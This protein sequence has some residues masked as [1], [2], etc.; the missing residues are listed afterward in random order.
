VSYQVLARKYRPQTFAEVVG[1]EHVVR[2]LSNAIATG[3]IAHAFLFVGPRGIGKTSIA[4]IL[5]KALNC[6]NGPKADFDPADP[7]CL[8]IAEGRSLDVIE[9]DGA[10]NNGVEQ[11]RDLRDNVQYMPSSGQFKVYIIDEVHMLSLAAFNA[12]LKTLEEPPAHVKFV[13]ATTEVH[14]VPAT[15]LS[16]CQRFD[17]RRIGDVEIASHLGLIAEKE[18]ITISA[19]AL[20]LLARNAE[21]GLRDAESALDQLITFC[22]KS[23]EEKDVLEMFGLTGIREIWDLAEA[24]QAADAEPAIRQVRQLVGR[25]K[26]LLQLTR[27]LVRY[28]RN[29]LIYGISPELAASQLDASE[30]QHFSAMQP[31][32]KRELILAWIEELVRL[33]EKMRHALVKEVMFEITIIR[34]SQQREKVELEELLLQITGGETPPAL[35]LPPRAEPVKVA[36]TP[37]PRPEPAA[38][39]TPAPIP[40][41]DPTPTPPPEP[42]PKPVPEPDPVPP[43]KPV[44]E[45]KPTAEVAPGGKA[46]RAPEK[47]TASAAP[48]M[49]REITRAD[50]E[51]F[52][53][54]PLIKS[55]VDHY[56]A[57]L[58]EVKEKPTTAA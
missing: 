12:L 43:Q 5:A 49:K 21:G 47:A 46:E 3:R 42:L 23:I 45:K 50:K 10:S 14:K 13:F 2:A 36:P 56:E 25:G 11:V 44:E 39:A 58:V 48:K 57:R 33:E 15:I 17:L 38:P 9:I 8:E 7:V 41:P 32:P 26:D 19:D 27:E 34:L 30:V 53:E 55:A 18:G 1:Q 37:V 22:G 51:M 54:D 29:Q 31:L 35:P 4:R 24:I 40:K 20:T 28:F 16:R 6:T 52:L